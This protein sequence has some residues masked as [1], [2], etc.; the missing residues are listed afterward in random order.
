MEEKKGI[1]RRG[2]LKTAAAAGAELTIQPVIDKA[3]AANTTL[4][5][6]NALSMK[7][8]G[9]PHRTLGTGKA[10]FEVSAIGFG[11]MG[12]T[13]NRCR[14]PDKKQCIRLLHEA[15]ER[16]VTL[17]ETAVAAISVVGNRYNA[18]QQK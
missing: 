11:V 6:E 15:V 16:G 7:K 14:H 10:A 8:D 18:E 9:M 3:K 17:F 12:M 5:G 2:F 1:S 4:G 13:Y